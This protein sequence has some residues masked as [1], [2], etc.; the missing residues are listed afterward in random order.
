MA[1]FKRGNLQL[2][3]N[4]KIQLGDSQESLIRFDGSDLKI[5]VDGTNVLRLNT[6]D[7][8]TLGNDS[9]GKIYTTATGFFAGAY[10]PASILQAGTATG[11]LTV[12]SDVAFLG[13]VST[14]HAIQYSWNGTAIGL[15]TTG[16]FTLIMGGDYAIHAY[17]TDDSDGIVQ[18][19]VHPA[20]KSGLSGTF[21]QVDAANDTIDHS[22]DSP[23]GLTNNE[24]SI[25]Q[26]GIKLYNGTTS[27]DS[28]LS[29]TDAD[30]INSSS[31]DNQL[32]TAKLVYDH[33]GDMSWDSTA[34]TLTVVGDIV[35]DDLYVSNNTIFV[36]TGQIKST[37]GN[38]E[39]YNSGDKVLEILSAGIEITNPAGPYTADISFNG[40]DLRIR[41]LNNNQPVIISTADGS[42]V[43]E[44]GLRVTL[45]TFYAYDNGIQA[46]NATQNGIV[47]QGA[48][49][50]NTTL[51]SYDGY[52]E[53][54]NA[55]HG[56]EIRF[57]SEDTGGTNRTLFVGK[58]DG[59]SELYYGG[60]NVA[61]TTAYGLQN[62]LNSIFITS[63]TGWS[64]IA[65]DTLSFS[66]DSTAMTFT[67][68][69]SGGSFDFWVQ[70][71]KYTKTGDDS[72][73]IT[74]TEGEWYITYN[75]SGVLTASQT[76]W[77][78][79]DEDAALVANIYW[80]A[81]NKEANFLGMELHTFSMPSITHYHLHECIGTLYEEGFG[82]TDNADGT[83][84]ISGGQLHDEDISIYVTDDIG[85]G[86][87]DQV[88]SPAELP[89]Y[90]KDGASGLWRRVYN[91]TSPT[92][93]TYQDGGDNPYWNQFTGGTW[94]LTASANNAYS[95][96]WILATNNIMEP[97]VVVMG[98]GAPS[99]TQSTAISNNDINSL[100]LGG[101]GGQEYKIIY[102]VMVQNSGAPYTTATITDF[103]TAQSV[104]G[105]SN[106]VNDHG[107]LNGL[108]DDDH[109]QYALVD[110]S[111]DFTGTVGGIDPVADTDFVTLGYM[112]ELGTGTQRI[113]YDSTAGL[114]ISIDKI[115]DLDYADFTIGQ[116]A[117]PWKEGRV[118]WD[119][120]SHTFGVYND[121][122]DVT[123]QVG[124]ETHIR[125]KNETGSQ[126]NNGQVVYISGASGQ[127]PLV[128]L[129][130]ATDHDLICNTSLATHNIGNG[131]FG[132]V[133]VRGLVRG[134]N[135]SSWGAGD[136][137]YVSA[138]VPGGLQNTP[139]DPPNQKAFIGTVIV[140]GNNGSIL[141]NPAHHGGTEQLSDV[142]NSQT[143]NSILVWD[144]TAQY[145]VTDY[146][147]SN[148]GTLAADSN[149]NIPTE[150]AT[151]QYVDS[152]VSV[153]GTE[154]ISNDSTTVVVTFSTA[155]ADTNYSIAASFVNL[156]D[157]LPLDLTYKIT[158]KATTGFTATFN[159]ATD[160]ANY[161]FDWIIK[162]H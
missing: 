102:R 50:G 44:T 103:R 159:E 154:S 19:G 137:L 145:Y 54:Y 125:V 12:L 11:D 133:T 105:T 85:S 153:A 78:I 80:D 49:T 117:P 87:W 155:Q 158:A 135:T 30:V 26:D 62:P 35:C 10:G 95:A 115:V 131:E 128:S 32:V 152:Q 111:R 104:G 25:S 63:K 51:R 38:I 146:N 124:Q 40:D 88:L 94:Q 81:T 132:Y 31:T 144:G 60:A 41:N 98:Q 127:Q 65:K 136:R 46:F 110:G 130:I 20:A 162:H 73:V 96:W 61:E 5:A 64:Y 1:K 3:T 13:S 122:S 89:I 108:G 134:V 7:E 24:L 6:S 151:K 107:A 76:P 67:I 70:G 58:S 126:I 120:D 157:P 143:D 118:F 33:I 15:G 68:S 8:V 45:G 21:I 148:D 48:A 72:V 82:I 150:A 69:D 97:V 119:D 36:G 112:T 27:V 116:G 4:Q 66:F 77:E 28:I 29:V 106:T 90:Y 86:W 147:I 84:D 99:I 114:E 42:G 91:G 22:I 156:T 129:A 56:S 47:L 113:T 92:Y 14:L 101:F 55:Q 37:A 109:T 71:V 18:V 34:L 53:I 121:V 52:F 9:I 57:V 39:L 100:D 17:G 161:D 75:N 139:P 160:S 16:D 74:D 2:N 79:E 142:S 141:V 149:T 23:S 138:T 123:L 83:I 93:F 59:A 140:S 43:Q